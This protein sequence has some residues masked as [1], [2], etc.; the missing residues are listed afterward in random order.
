MYAAALGFR[1]EIQGFAEYQIQAGGGHA[2][3]AYCDE[4]GNSF[5]S[6]LQPGD[7]FERQR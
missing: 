7:G 1:F 5:W 2:C 6:E 3:A 4:V